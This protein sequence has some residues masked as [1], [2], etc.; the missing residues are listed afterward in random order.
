M[1]YI[2]TFVYCESTQNEMTPQGPKLNLI[3]PMQILT[4]MF[5]PSMF[6]FSVL[7]GIQDFRLNQAHTVRLLFKGPVEGEQPV[8]DTGDLTLP[9]EHQ[10][11]NLPEDMQ[12]MMMNLDFRNLAIRH[13][14]TYET[15]VYFDG[16]LLGKY[17]IKVIAADR[18]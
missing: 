8:V 6:S 5:I 16:E 2:T 15:E 12:G 18:K 17:P 3:G 1:A 11:S 13:K 9:I 10:N 7:F 14:G 4:P